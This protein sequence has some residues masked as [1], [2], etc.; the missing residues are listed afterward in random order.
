MQR[1][2]EAAQRQGGDFF[3]KFT[4]FQKNTTRFLTAL[5]AIPGGKAN[6]QI[7]LYDFDF[8]FLAL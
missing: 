7:N 1:C 5:Q 8:K 4:S 2:Q 3:E 6:K